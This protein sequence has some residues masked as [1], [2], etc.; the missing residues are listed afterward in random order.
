M[1]GSVNGFGR[2]DRE[3]ATGVAGFAVDDAADAFG[4]GRVRETTLCWE[5]PRG[6]GSACLSN[7]FAG[8]VRSHRRLGFRCLDSVPMNYCK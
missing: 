4:S 6:Q 8:L 1:I 7:S 2:R 5:A 3:W